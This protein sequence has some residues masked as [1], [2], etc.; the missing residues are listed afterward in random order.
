MSMLV[1]GGRVGEG[2]SKYEYGNVGLSVC[3]LVS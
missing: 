2:V 3:V 1:G